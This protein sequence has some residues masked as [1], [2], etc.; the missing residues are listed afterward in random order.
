MPQPQQNQWM[1]DTAFPLFVKRVFFEQFSRGEKTID[2][3][4]GY[5]LGLVTQIV[6]A[7]ELRKAALELAATLIACSPVSLRITKKLLGDFAA[8]EIARELELAATERWRG[9]AR[10]GW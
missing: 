1:S 10:R 2:A 4:E 9:S 8:P 3:A 6:A 7:E 5:R